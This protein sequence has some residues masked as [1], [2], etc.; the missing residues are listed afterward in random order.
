MTS[1]RIENRLIALET[2]SLVARLLSF[3][4]AAEE[5]GI[6]PSA[7]SRR[8]SQLEDSLGC[9]LF[10][11]TTRKVSLTEA[12]SVYLRFINEALS[13]IADGQAAVSNFTHEPSGHLR[14]TLPN[15]YGQRRIA[16]K[17]SMFMLQ[18]PKLTLELSF[19][20]RYVD[21][22]AEGFDL[23]IRIGILKDSSLIA[24]K[25]SENNRILCAS[26]DFIKKY[27]LPK[28]PDELSEYACLQ[29]RHGEERNSWHLKSKAESKEVQIR[30]AVIADNAEAVRRLALSG[31]GIC[32]LAEFLVEDD[33]KSGSLERILTDWSGTESSIWLVYPSLRFVPFKTKVLIN[34]LS[35]EFGNGELR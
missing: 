27:G 7:L 35:K 3:N 17:L 28:S 5:L 22:V 6:S 14:V 29:F 10:Q 20:D 32:L 34:F 30:P 4:E 8:I 2:F 19:S 31:V 18:Y 11:R 21:M 33:L 24:R 23:G 16:P 15:L 12:G 25:L 26:P 9:R 1:D 13:T